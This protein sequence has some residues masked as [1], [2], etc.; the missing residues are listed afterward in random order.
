MYFQRTV[1]VLLGAGKNRFFALLRMTDSPLVPLL[2]KR[3]GIPSYN[4]L[5]PAL[6]LKRRGGLSS[7]SPLTPLLVREGELSSDSPIANIF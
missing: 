2:V 1:V 4:Y 3:G 5:T 6:S 7:D